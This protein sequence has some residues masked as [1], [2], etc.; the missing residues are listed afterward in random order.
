MPVRIQEIPLVKHPV[1]VRPPAT[2]AAVRRFSPRSPPARRR[3]GPPDRRL[4]QLRPR[5]S[6]IA[7]IVPCRR[8]ACAPGSPSTPPAPTSGVCAVGDPPSPTHSAQVRRPSVETPG[9][10]A[11]GDRRAAGRAGPGVRASSIGVGPHVGIGYARGRRV[12]QAG[13]PQGAA[14]GC[15]GSAASWRWRMRR[16]AGLGHRGRPE[17]GGEH[18]GRRA[19]A[20]A[21]DA[22]LGR[23]A[24]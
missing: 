3:T 13:D 10:P 12:R 9:L 8:S 23:G 14:A 16:D 18:R 24:R 17:P 7:A 4:G 20:V 11:F 21:G 22:E 6:A 1:F 2:C 19:Q 5:G 15:L